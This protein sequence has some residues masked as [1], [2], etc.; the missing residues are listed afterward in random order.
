MPVS[1]TLGGLFF[2]TDPKCLW[3]DRGSRLTRERERER[4]R[5]RGGGLTVSDSGF[6]GRPRFL[7]SPV[8]VASPAPSLSDIFPVAV[9]P[10]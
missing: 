8:S 7:F 2:S 6:L 1:S 9:C 4:E 5:E 3:V 10:I